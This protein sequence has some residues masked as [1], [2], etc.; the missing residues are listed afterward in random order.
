VSTASD[1]DMGEA[2]AIASAGMTSAVGVGRETGALDVTSGGAETG[3]G[4]GV[5]RGTDSGGAA[6]VFL[7]KSH[8]LRVAS[9]TCTRGGH[10]KR[11]MRWGCDQRRS[12]GVSDSTIS[13]H[14]IA[15]A[16]KNVQYTASST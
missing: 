16:L 13:L 11:P 6:S 12:S 3:S 5:S 15:V 1:W 7:E 2:G 9:G 10:D 14:G 8:M 4:M